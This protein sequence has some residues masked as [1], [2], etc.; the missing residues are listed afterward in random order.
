ME[1]KQKKTHALKHSLKHSRSKN[2]IK[3]CTTQKVL[4][5]TK[6]GCSIIRL[7]DHCVSSSQGQASE[8]EEIP[9]TSFGLTP[10]LL[11]LYLH[12]HE[13]HPQVLLFDV[14]LH[15]LDS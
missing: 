12:A 7:D 11:C 3:K 4:Q 9:T 5:L 14:E 8:S 2:E 10:A 1:I 13:L 6:I 15:L